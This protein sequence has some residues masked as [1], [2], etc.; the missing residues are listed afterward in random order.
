MSFKLVVLV[1]FFVFVQIQNQI[2]IKKKANS[3]LKIPIKCCEE[4]VSV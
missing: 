4:Q 3:A 1:A 2:L